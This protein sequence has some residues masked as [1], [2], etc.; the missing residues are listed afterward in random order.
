MFTFKLTDEAG[1]ETEVKADSRDVL[2]WEKT[3]K[4]N[5]RYI[6]LLTEMSLV[7]FYRLAHIAAKRQ[8]VVTGKLA[9]FETDYVLE[10]DHEDVLP[11]NAGVTKET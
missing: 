7:K 4:S 1:E 6:D 3:S 9:D 10:L 5:E 11:T 2:V 8:G